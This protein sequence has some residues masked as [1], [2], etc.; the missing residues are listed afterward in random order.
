MDEVEVDEVQPEPVQ[1]RPQRLLR[2]VGPLVPAAQLGGDEHLL[3]GEAG[4]GDALTDAALVLVAGGGVD[5][6]VA[7]VEGL[8]DDPPRL[9]VGQAGG[10]QPELGDRDTVVELYVRDRGHP[11]SVVSRR[12]VGQHPPW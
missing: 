7:D 12:G 5:E 9:L 6:A 11:A 4:V 2:R 8:A 3:P 10:A 1:A